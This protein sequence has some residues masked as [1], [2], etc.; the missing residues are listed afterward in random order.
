MH[1][2][3]RTVV[4]ILFA[5]ALG[6][7]IAYPAAAAEQQTVPFTFT[8]TPAQCPDLASTVSGTGEYF[9]RTNMRVDADGVIHINQNT[10]ANGTA[11]DTEGNIYRFTYHNNQRITIPPDGFP[12]AVNV[13]DHFNLVGAGNAQS[14]RVGFTVRL[15]FSAPGEE[16]TVEVISF[17]GLL[18]C[19]PI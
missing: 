4:A 12:F 8:L 11:T 2:W 6:T 9:I 19:D 16:P 1:R 13:N 15:T 17:R 10:T 5:V 3:K 18:P 7:L 14:V